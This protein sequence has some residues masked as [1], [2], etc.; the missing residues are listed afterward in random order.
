[1]LKTVEIT[2]A[3]RHNGREKQALGVFKQAAINHITLTD[4]QIEVDKII[5]P[6]K[7]KKKQLYETKLELSDK[8]PA[9]LYLWH[10]TK[11]KQDRVIC[12]AY[13]N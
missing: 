10:L 11:G 2:I 5:A 6:K 8:F 3:L 9:R 7:K 12:M 4:M 1:M 13:E